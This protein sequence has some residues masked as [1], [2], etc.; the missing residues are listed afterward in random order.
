MTNLFPGST[1]SPTTSPTLA[2]QA[3]GSSAGFY[4]TYPSLDERTATN[5][6]LLQNCLVWYTMQPGQACSSNA[7]CPGT[8]CNLTTHEC[9]QPNACGSSSSAISARTAYLYQINATDGSTNCGLTGSNAIRTPAP[10]NSFLVPP[11]PPQPLVSINS[12]GQVSFAVRAPVGQLSPQ[13]TPGSG[14]SALPS[15]F[16]YTIETPRELHQ[17]RHPPQGGSATPLACY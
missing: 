2:A 16:Y 1:F 10:V 4:F 6:V 14:G 7:D 8:T 5:A 11:P 3:T 13:G 17:C 9:V 15:I 12:K